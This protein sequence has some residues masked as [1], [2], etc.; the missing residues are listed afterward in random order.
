[1]NGRGL[2]WERFGR[3]KSVMRRFRGDLRICCTWPE[4]VRL[5]SRCGTFAAPRSSPHPNVFVLRAEYHLDIYAK[6][7][8]VPL[9]TLTYTTYSSSTLGSTLQSQ[10]TQTPDGRYLQAMHSGSL[11][12]FLAGVPGVSWSIDFETPVV[13]VFDIAIPNVDEDGGATGETAQPVMFEQPH[14]LLVKDLPVDF[15]QLQ[16]LPESTFIGRVGDG[17][18]AM[19]R[20]HFP[21]V[22]F[23]PDHRVVPRLDAKSTEKT[24][25]D[26]DED[27]ENDVPSSLPDDEDDSQT[28]RGINCLVGRHR[29]R[30]TLSPGGTDRSSQIE[31]GSPP[32]L[33][34]EAPP[35]SSSSSP[36]PYHPPSH[37]SPHLPNRSTVLANLVYRPVRRISN[38]EDKGI[39]FFTILALLGWFYV[40]KISTSSSA[41]STDPQK[42]ASSSNITPSTSTSSTTSAVSIDHPPSPPLPL[43]TPPPPP[44]A[45]SFSTPSSPSTSLSPALPLSPQQQYTHNRA[46]S[47][48]LSLSPSLKELPPLP[49]PDEEDSDGGPR[50]GTTDEIATPRKKTRRRRGKKGKHKLGA[51]GELGLGLSGGEKLEEIKLEVRE[52]DEEDEDSGGNGNVVGLGAVGCVP[53]S[54]EEQ[55]GNLIGGLAVSETILG[56]STASSGM[57]TLDRGT[58]TVFFSCTRRLRFARYRRLTRRIPRSS[59]GRQTTTQRLRHH[60]NTRSRPPSRIRRPSSRHSI[61]LQRAT[62]H[63]PLHCS[64]A[65]SSILVRPHRSTYGTSRSRQTSRS[66]E[67]V[68][69]NHKWDSTP[70]QTQNRSSRHQTSKHSRFDYSSWC[71]RRSRHSNA[72]F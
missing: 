65:L 49:P 7:S 54:G 33:L 58:D 42:L 26:D 28:C 34:I 63:V 44:P 52:E 66:E 64:R 70:S 51:N 17:L 47:T 18:F 68:K 71:F 39:I 23:A 9:Q 62:R 10:W 24:Y 19:S 67:G 43:K 22:S 1:M 15:N 72:H 25:E 16:Q 41:S 50:D 32:P 45:N 5:E 2:G 11:V 13:S 48:S 8:A 69:G 37:S 56:T 27:D 4:L 30:P 12:C 21:L 55:T 29:V 59:S 20:D 46:R 36:P 31:A 40:R 14:P 57:I 60:R 3:M 61:L 6:S 38:G 53:E 35:T